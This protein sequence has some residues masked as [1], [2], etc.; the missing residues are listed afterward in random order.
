MLFALLVNG[1]YFVAI[2]LLRHD[3]ARAKIATS[4]LVGFMPLTI[5]GYNAT[6]TMQHYAPLVLWKVPKHA[7]YVTAETNDQPALSNCL[8]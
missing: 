3:R 5:T 4:E 8:S 6:D 7:I 2:S 1:R